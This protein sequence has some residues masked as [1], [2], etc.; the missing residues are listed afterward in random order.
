MIIEQAP[1]HVDHKFRSYLERMFINI[2]NEFRLVHK[3]PPRKTM[4]LKAS[5]GA[6]YYFEAAIASTPITGEGLWIYKS[7]GWVQIV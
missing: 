5:I 2:D 6:V 7:T 1:D 3:F 4:P